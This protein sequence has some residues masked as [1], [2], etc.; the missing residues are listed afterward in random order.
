M[1]KS[2]VFFNP[3]FL[4]LNVEQEEITQWSWQLLIC[5]RKAG[6]RGSVSW[7]YTNILKTAIYTVINIV[8]YATIE[9]K[10]E[11][12]VPLKM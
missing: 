2:V 1:L 11:N 10:R 5:S 4:D 12:T 9:E 6:L 3:L 7:R 8:W